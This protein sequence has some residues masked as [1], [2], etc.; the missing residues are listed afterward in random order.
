MVFYSNEGKKIIGD[1]DPPLS[2]RPESEIKNAILSPTK[3]KENDIL[4][5]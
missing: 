4:P 2:P 5:L 1:P 3:A